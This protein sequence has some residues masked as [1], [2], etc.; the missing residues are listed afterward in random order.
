LYTFDIYI[1]SLESRTVL[2]LSDYWRHHRF[3][4]EHQRLCY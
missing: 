2:F 4:E 1:N 3:S